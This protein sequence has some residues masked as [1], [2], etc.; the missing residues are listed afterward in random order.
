MS[1]TTHGGRSILAVVLDW[2]GTTVD[3]GSRAPVAAVS[4]AFASRGIELTEGEAR[5]PMGMAKRAHIGMLL[6][7]PGIADRWTEQVGTQPTERDADALYAEFQGVQLDEIGRHADLIPG[8]IEAVREL[9]RRGIA[10]GS[11]TGYFRRAAVLAAGFAA[12]AGFRPDALVAAD[13][14][15]AGRPEP[16]MLLRA[17]EALRVFPPA[18]SVKVGDTKVD[19]G[20]G[21]NAGAWAV[22]VTETGNEIGL[23]AEALAALDPLDRA[24]RAE[25]AAEALRAGGAHETIRSI[26]ELPEAIDRIGLRIAAGERPD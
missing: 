17:L 14:V 7:D 3:F 5:G 1:D 26:A 11:T 23:G 19:M 2:A 4:R 15:P 13:D 24:A 20:E 6:A 12:E 21:R 16:W 9:R 22:G 18:R 25:R 10:I 8:T